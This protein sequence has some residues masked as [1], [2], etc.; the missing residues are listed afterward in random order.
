MANNIRSIKTQT[1]P[2]SYS[3]IGQFCTRY[4]SN[5]YSW[6]VLYAYG[7]QLPTYMTVYS[8]S[9]FN[10]G[11]R[12]YRTFGTSVNVFGPVPLSSTSV[13]FAGNITTNRIE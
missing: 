1:Y 12:P 7:T 13:G 5:F 8:I 10:G 2:W 9:Y 3:N 6:S 4:D 11:S